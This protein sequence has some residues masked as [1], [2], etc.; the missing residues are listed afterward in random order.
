MDLNYLL[1]RHQT[2]LMRADRA[3]C[4]PSRCAHAALAAGYADQIRIVQRTSGALSR[5]IAPAPAAA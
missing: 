4:G 3:A 2:S 1:T 5:A